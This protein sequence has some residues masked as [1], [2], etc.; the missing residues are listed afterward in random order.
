MKCALKSHSIGNDWIWNNGS[1]EM[2]GDS[3]SQQ[4]CLVNIYKVETDSNGDK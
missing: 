4:Y 2:G 1:E 3:T